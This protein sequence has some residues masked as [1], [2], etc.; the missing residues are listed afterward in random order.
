MKTMKKSVSILMAVMMIL[1][2]WVFVAPVKAHGITSQSAGTYTFTVTF[3]ISNNGTHDHDSGWGLTTDDT[4]IIAARTNGNNGRNSATYTYDYWGSTG[5]KT[6]SGGGKQSYDGGFPD[7]FYMMGNDNSILQ[8]VKAHITSIVISGKTVWTGTMHVNS[9]TEPYYCYVYA[10]GR[11]TDGGNNSSYG[12]TQ[13]TTKDWPMPSPTVTISGDTSVTTD[14]STTKTYAISTAKDQYGVNWGFSSVTWSSNHSAATINNNGV[15]TFGNNNG[16]DY[17]V[18]FTPTLVHSSGNKQVNGITVHVNTSKSITYNLDGG[19][20]SGNPTSYN[21]ETTPVELNNPTK[22]GYTF[23]GWTGSNGSTPQTNVA[24]ANVFNGTSA[25]TK[26]SPYTANSRDH[27][28]GDEFGVCPGMVYRVYVTAKRTAGSLNMLGGIW[29]TGQT[30]GNA[31]DGSG[32]AFTYLRD[33]GNGW[34]VYYK[35]VTVPSAK[36]KGKF[37]VLLEQWDSD[38]NKTT[39][40]LS[41][42][43]VTSQFSSMPTGLSGYTTSNPYTC[44]N[45]DHLMGNS[46]PVAPGERYRVFVTGKRTSG[47]LSIQGGLWYTAQTSGDPW[48]S[49]SGNFTLLADLGDGWGRYYKDITIPSGK[50][51]AQAYIQIDQSH[52]GHEGNVWKIADIVVA[53]YNMKNLSYTANWSIN[54]SKL[55]VKPNGGTWNNSSSNQD[56]TQNYNTTRS[57]ADPTPPSGKHFTGWTKSS[58]FNGSLSGKTYTYG[59]A[60]NA[61]DTLTA[62]YSAHTFDVGECTANPTYDSDGVWTCTCDY[63]G[64]GATKTETIPKLESLI[65]LDD[66]KLEDTALSGSCSIAPSVHQSDISYEIVGFSA[67]GDHTLYK[68]SDKPNDG[69]TLKLTNARIRKTSASSFSYKFSSMDFTNLESFYVLVKVS[70]TNL[71]KYSV[72]DVYTYEK[73]TL[74]PPK[75]VMFDDASPAISFNDSTTPSGGYG[76]WVRIADSGSPVS[77]P[78]AVDDFGDLATAQQSTENSV[79]YSFGDAHRVSVSNTI[80]TDW[81]TAQFTFTGSGFD[82]ISVTDSNSGIFG[83]KVYQ[84][85]DTNVE[86]PYKSKIVDT[87]YG[88]T[89]T[90]LFYNQRTR[91]IVN[92]DDANGTTL[93]A[94]VST[95]PE[96]NRVYGGIGTYFY[97]MDDQYAVKDSGN[98]P[99]VAYGWLKSTSSDV[100]Y[101]VP[102][103]NMDLGEVGTYTVIIQPMFTD[104][105]GHYNESGDVKYYN[106]TLDGIRIYNP[107]GGNNEALALYAVNGETYTSYELVRVTI[108]DASLV[109]IDGKD[110]LDE[111]QLPGYLAGAPKNE[112]YLKKNGTAAFDVNFTNLTDARIGLRALNGTACTVMIGNGS[113]TPKTIQVMSATEQYYSLKDLLTSGSSSTITITNKGDGILSLTRLMTTTNTAPPSPSGAPRRYLSVGP[114]TA[115]VALETV[116][117]FNADIAIDEETIETASSDDG[118][119]TITLQTGA[120]A[121]TVVVRDGEG[122]VVDPDSIEFTIDEDGVKNWTVVLA[123]SEMGEYTYT[124]QAEYENGYAPE[125]PTTVTVTVSFPKEP[126]TEESTDD[127]STTGRFSKLMDFFAKL[128]EFV[129]RII[130]LFR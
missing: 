44:S 66:V 122:N 63:S 52:D 33:A 121:Q 16:E 106:F 100:L 120:D 117:M 107:A 37:Y 108:S 98:N 43:Y 31:W 25:Y 69:T 56:F 24:V 88:Y 103:L 61:T 59:P 3:D 19:S 99:V 118:T 12:Y 129:K 110:Q 70:G 113:G 115:Q 26:D 75:N 4:F 15:A 128:I 7:G 96:A 114:N 48:D 125:E 116:E 78:A 83:V 46:F 51:Q 127:G 1:T 64:C 79:R 72:S 102:C 22:T 105:L 68:S 73:V 58:D 17:D 104:A 32:G 86:K 21:C 89:Y 39:W 8:G 85:T 74:V 77:A 47:T 97:T 81:P 90:Q 34:G 109:V 50:S 67:T 40:L 38:S 53:S 57:I 54:S 94:A 45:R 49:Y 14:G 60:N 112:L 2:A 71:H 42:C 10:D 41:N 27:V 76:Q 9:T 80:G 30:S 126:I 91:K 6:W 28:L 29:Y 23:T 87:Y 20:A 130:T 92:S 95:T 35:D 55:T 13:T 111:Q 119:V 82:V 65:S 11:G 123:E 5:N 62:G 84:G 101:Q 93:Y 18:T 36:Q 124:L